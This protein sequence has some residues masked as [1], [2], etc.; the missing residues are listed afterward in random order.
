MS[1]TPHSP[2]SVCRLL[3]N[4]PEGTRGLAFDDSIKQLTR[5]QVTGS[6][7]D[8]PT[9]IQAEWRDGEGERKADFPT[10]RPTGPVLSQ[11]LTRVLGEETLMR[12]GTLM[13][14]LINGVEQNE[15]R[16]YVVGQVVDCLDV[17]LSSEPESLT[18]RIKESVFR[19]EAVP[20]DLP[21]FR[22]PQYPMAVHWNGWAADILA[23][24]LGEELEVRLIWSEDPGLAPHPNPWGF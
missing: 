18:G 21:A 10:G 20:V 13:P 22:I 17:E 16:L 2:M 6:A 5:W 14:L 23:R 11:R 7:E 8:R 15:H 1:D 24:E 19:P 12:A 4:I 9:A 3:P